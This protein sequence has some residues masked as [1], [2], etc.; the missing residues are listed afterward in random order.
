MAD[1]LQGIQDRLVCILRAAGVL[2]ACDH[3]ACIHESKKSF[4][5]IRT[6]P[7]KIGAM[8]RFILLMAVVLVERAVGCGPGFEPSV[9]GYIAADSRVRLATTWPDATRFKLGI[10]V[11]SQLVSLA[12]TRTRMLL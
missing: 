11:T 3:R 6:L 7:S 12:N 9:G 8:D 1:L 4:W 5:F 2:P 10:S